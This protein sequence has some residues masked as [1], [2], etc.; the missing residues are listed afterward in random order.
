MIHS[1]TGFGRHEAPLGD[2]TVIVEVRSLNGR[3]SDIRIK[4]SLHLGQREMDLRK[5]IQEKALRGKIDVLVEVQG[6]QSADLSIPNTDLITKYYTELRTIAD[7]LGVEDARIFSSILKLPNVF[8]SQNGEMDQ[9][10]WETLEST[11]IRAL[12]KLNTFRAT[13]GKSLA[14]DLETQIQE[15]LRLLDK[16]D[17]LEAEREAALKQRLTQKIADVDPESVDRNRF[18]QEVLHYLEKLDINEEKVRLAQHCKYFL[19]ELHTPVVAKGK[20]LNFISQEIGREINTLGAKAQWSMIQRIVV[21][22]K[23][24]LERIKEQL[25]NA[26]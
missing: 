5:V 19:Q 13:E 26:L 18:E 22:M 11:T 3:Q 16:I 15:I 7:D 9:E 10:L 21:Q 8:Q 4:S 2:K 20:K 25:A 17:P 1:M 12:E 14:R 23:D 6:M 24:A